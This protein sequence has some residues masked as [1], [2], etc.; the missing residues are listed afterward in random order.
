[1]GGCLLFNT[2]K[3]AVNPGPN[4]GPYCAPKLKSS[5]MPHFR[6]NFSYLAIAKAATLALMKQYA[7]E[8]GAHNI[9]SSAVNA[10]RVRTQFFSE[11]QTFFSLGLSLLIH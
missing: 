5:S 1:M 8:Y 11:V 6:L 4:F 7:L 2:S 3:A 10:D 9:R